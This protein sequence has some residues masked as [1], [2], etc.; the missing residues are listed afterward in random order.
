MSTKVY[1]NREFGLTIFRDGD[2]YTLQDENNFRSERFKAPF[3][4]P[5]RLASKVYA[6]LN[7]HSIPEKYI[8]DILKN[9]FKYRVQTAINE[10]KNKL[11]NDEYYPHLSNMSKLLEIVGNTELDF[12][13]T[14]EQV[15]IVA[16]YVDT[17]LNNTNSESS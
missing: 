16:H 17:A 10:C 11:M 3:V 8:N 7:H 13:P 9:L 1:K 2:H 6:Y 4:S 15:S 14:A 12:L 5:G